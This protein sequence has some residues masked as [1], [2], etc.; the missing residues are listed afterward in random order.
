[1]DI[2]NES[3]LLNRDSVFCFSFWGCFFLLF[4]CCCVFVLFFPSVVSSTFPGAV[5][6]AFVLVMLNNGPLSVYE[7]VAILMHRKEDL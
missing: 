3:N 6:P 5:R 2:D 4:V 1:M 7:A